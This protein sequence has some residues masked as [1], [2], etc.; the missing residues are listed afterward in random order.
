MR[1][2]EL[3]DEQWAVVAPLIP[4]RTRDTS[5]RGR[6]RRDP[7]EVL[8][9][10]LWVLRCSA[11]WHDLP[12]RF[13]SYQTCHRRFQQWVSDGTLRLVLETLE[14][15][16]RERGRLDVTEWLITYTSAN[17]EGACD[18]EGRHDEASEGHVSWQQQTALLFLSRTTLKLLRRLE[19]PLARRLSIRFL[20]QAEQ[21]IASFGLDAASCCR[22][23]R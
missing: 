2:E 10:V 20:P 16:L 14:E 11:H 6:P 13:P 21:L 19:S 23:R 5:Q 4:T 3:T 9:G 1:R 18:E 8:S 7:R 15:D 22:S 12:D 17:C